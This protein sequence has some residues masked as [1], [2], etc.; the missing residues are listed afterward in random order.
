MPVVVCSK[1]LSNIAG[2]RLWRC[3]TSLWYQQANCCRRYSVAR[4]WLR[5]V[6]FFISTICMEIPE[7]LIC[8]HMQVFSCSFCVAAVIMPVNDVAVFAMGANLFWWPTCTCGSNYAKKHDPA[9][10]CLPGPVALY[11]DVNL[12]CSTHR[13]WMRVFLRNV[14]LVSMLLH[15]CDNG[16][17]FASAHRHCSTLLELDIRFSSLH[18]EL[19]IFITSDDSAS[20]QVSSDS[21]AGMSHHHVFNCLP[22]S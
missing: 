8:S 22:T 21:G 16:S 15:N 4:C 13:Y 9:L 12:T 11:V 6:I 14:R 5:L 1:T 20:D 18:H 19:Y 2:W 7:N 17:R 3:E 10:A